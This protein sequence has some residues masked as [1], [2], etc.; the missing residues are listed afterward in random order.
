MLDHPVKTLLLMATLQDELPFRAYLPK[1][2][3]LFLR[4]SGCPLPTN[5]EILVSDVSYFGDEGGIMCHVDLPQN[6]LGSKPQ[7]PLILGSVAN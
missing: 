3:I 4:K 2:T 7:G 5:S 1:K 6:K